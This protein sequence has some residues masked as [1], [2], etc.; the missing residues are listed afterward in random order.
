M[1]PISLMHL[2]KLL[3]PSSRSHWSA[4]EPRSK[5]QPTAIAHTRSGN[6]HDTAAN[7]PNWSGR[8]LKPVRLLMLDFASRRQG[9]TGKTGLANRSDRF[10]PETPRRPKTPQEPFHVWTNEAMVQQRLPCSKTLLDSPQGETGQAGFCL[11]RQEEC[12]PWEKLNPSSNRSPDSFHGSKW[13]FGD[14][15]GTSWATLG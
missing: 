11:D 15:W 14:S 10:C 13:D 4:T 5:I 6:T 7:S 2:R 8:F 9:E 3:L 12:S 1:N